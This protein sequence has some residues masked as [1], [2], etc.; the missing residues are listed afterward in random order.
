MV[1]NQDK[2]P[3][4]QKNHKIDHYWFFEWLGELYLEALDNVKP[5]GKPQSIKRK[6]L[7]ELNN[8]EN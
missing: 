1:K 2:Q 6:F 8:E 4:R 7:R 3:C 5:C